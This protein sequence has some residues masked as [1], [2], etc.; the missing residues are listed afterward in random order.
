[1]KGKG[2][3]KTYFLTSSPEKNVD[4]EFP[5]DFFDDKLIENEEVP[6]DVP[7]IPHSAGSGRSQKSPVDVNGINSENLLKP[8]PTPRKISEDS[9][10]KSSTCTIF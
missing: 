3:M 9:Y 5:E 10:D 4:F 6:V 2:K 1:M 7:E 8:D